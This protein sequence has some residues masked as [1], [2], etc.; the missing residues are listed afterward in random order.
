MAVANTKS[1]IVTNADAAPVTLTPAYVKDGRLREQAATV[2][3]AAADDAGSVYRLFRVH[4]SWRISDILIGHDA[5]TNMTT[6]DVGV[7]DTAANGGAVVNVSL[8]A[9]ALNMSSASAG[10]VNHT[11]EAT[12]TN[13]DKIEKRLWELLGLTSDPNKEYDIAVTATT[14]DPSVAGTISGLCRYVSNA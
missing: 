2:E 8:F 13:I 9:S 4:S 10:L 11:Y 14:N 12:A 7:Y 3:T 5:I 6:A 1:T